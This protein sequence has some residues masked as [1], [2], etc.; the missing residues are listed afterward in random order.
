MYFDQQ[1]K[2]KSTTSDE[3]IFRIASTG[4]PRIIMGRKSCLKEPDSSIN[5]GGGVDLNFALLP[6]SAFLNVQADLVPEF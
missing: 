5:A 2:S 1:V 6:T 3:Y 4:D